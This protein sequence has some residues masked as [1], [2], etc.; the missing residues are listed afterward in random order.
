MTGG[1]EFEAL[2]GRAGCDAPSCWSSRV[3]ARC[4]LL[5]D[6]M[7][8]EGGYR[9]RAVPRTEG[10]AVQAARRLDHRRGGGEACAEPAGHQQRIPELAHPTGRRQGQR[11]TARNPLRH[12]RCP[13]LANL[14]IL[15]DSLTSR[16]RWECQWTVRRRGLKEAIAE[17]DE[18]IASAGK[19]VAE[20]GGRET[21]NREEDK[22]MECPQLPYVKPGDILSGRCV[23]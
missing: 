17:R 18:G 9:R 11:G 20:V 1:K 6:I 10:F 22:P 19:S 3:I 5:P 2:Q 12:P 15:P 7:R 23:P 8:C 14:R 16:S 21:I 13:T 4:R